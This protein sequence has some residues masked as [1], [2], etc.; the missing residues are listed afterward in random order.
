MKILIILICLLMVA[1]STKQK[2]IDEKATVP[3]Q[4]EQFHEQAEVEKIDKKENTEKA[5]E[6]ENKQLPEQAAKKEKLPQ[7]KKI[8]SK[9]RNHSKQHHNEHRHKPDEKT[10]S[11]TVEVCGES[12]AVDPNKFFDAIT[13]EYWKPRNKYEKW[14]VSKEEA[15][16]YYYKIV[17]DPAMVE[18]E[19]TWSCVTDVVN[20]RFVWYV[21]VIK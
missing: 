16:K 14:F 5:S 6:K 15:L 21:S 18:Y 12:I 11:Q 20:K 3:Q 19:M 10:Q 8:I 17:N 4:K 1:C 7:P 13:C 2:A 9:K